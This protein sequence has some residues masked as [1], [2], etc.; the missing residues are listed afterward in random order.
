MPQWDLWPPP[1]QVKLNSLRTSYRQHLG[2]SINMRES[3]ATQSFHG[4]ARHPIRLNRHPNIKISWYWSQVEVLDRGWDGNVALPN[5]EFMGL[6][7]GQG[8]FDSTNI[9]T[10]CSLWS[11][12]A[13]SRSLQV[14]LKFFFHISKF[15]VFNNCC[16]ILLILACVVTTHCH[17]LPRSSYLSWTVSNCGAMASPCPPMSCDVNR[18]KGVCATLTWRSLTCACELM[19]GAICAP[20]TQ[21]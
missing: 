9:N 3:V 14:T 13:M 5:I 4:L 19:F 16:C 15:D 10:F 1:P 21:S 17:P 11:S 2:P 7:W 8:G 18:L 6:R 12:L 20:P